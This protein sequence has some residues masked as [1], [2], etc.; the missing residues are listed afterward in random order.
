MSVLKAAAPGQRRPREPLRYRLRSFR[1]EQGFPYDQ[2]VW[3]HSR[4]YRFAQQRIHAHGQHWFRH[5]GPDGTDL[6]CHWC[7]LRATEP[8]DPA[9]GVARPHGEPT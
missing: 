3:A 5:C 8:D 2:Y 7:G 4:L 9:P 1:R 6:W